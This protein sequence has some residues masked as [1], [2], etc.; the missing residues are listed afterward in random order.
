MSVTFLRPAGGDHVG[1]GG[2]G[3]ED[4]RARRAA[5]RAAARRGRYRMIY[6]HPVQPPPEDAADA[7]HDFTQRCTDVV[8]DV[9]PPSPRAMAV[10]APPVAG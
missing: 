9:C 10:D 5:V 2:P 7:V 4:R 1:R 3:A 8:G 6:E